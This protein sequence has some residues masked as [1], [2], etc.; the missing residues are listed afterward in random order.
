MPEKTG[1][2]SP[3]VRTMELA[4]VAPPLINLEA[5]IMKDGVTPGARKPRG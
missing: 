4:P 3:T 2:K 5:G 1:P